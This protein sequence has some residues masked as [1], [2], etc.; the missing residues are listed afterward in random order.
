MEVQLQMQYLALAKGLTNR[1]LVPLDFDF[2]QT[3]KTN[4]KQDYYISLYRYEDRHLKLFKETNTLEGIKDVKTPKILFDFDDGLDIDAAR[5]DTLQVCA[6]LV[7]AGV[8]ED[9]IR[10]YFSGNKGFG[11]EVITDAELTRQE[12]VNVVFNLA[13]DLKTFDT[14]INDEQR[15]IRAPLSRHPVSK[16][17]KIPLSLHD[18]ASKSIDEIREAA[19]SNSFEQDPDSLY[20]ISF[21]DELNVLKNKE[22]KKVAREFNIEDIKG[23][24]ISDINFERC[25]KWLPKERYALQEGFFYGS[26][27][28]SKGE[29]NIAFMIMAATYRN[30][31]FSAEHTLG[32]LITMAD[33]QSK[34]TKESPYTEEKLQREVINVVFNPSW[35]GGI[36]SRDEELLQITRKRF[37]LSEVDVDKPNLVKIDD[38]AVRFKQF[39]KT[40]DQNRI[41]TGIESIDKNVILTTGMLVGL[42]GSPGSGKTTL[43][44]T[45]IEFLSKNDIPVIYESLDMYDN[46]LYTRMLQKYSGYDMKKIID[47]FK[48]DKP[49]E[50]LLNAYAKVIEGYSNVEFNFCSG[51]TVED[52]EK[53]VIDYKNYTGK[54]PKLLVVDYLEKVHGPFSDSTANGA[55]VASRLSDIAKN[56]D[57]CVLLLLQPQKS[58]GDPREELLSM[59]KIKGASVIEQDCRVILTMWRPAY[60]PQDSSDD[61][62]M[63][64][65]V[66]KNNMGSLTQIDLGWNG[67]QGTFFELEPEDRADLK[68][69]RKK[70]EEQKVMIRDDI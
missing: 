28:I 3:V 1:E 26:E 33:K 11:V 37:N 63:S 49:D 6:R 62:Y 35:H 67:L 44:N 69:L 61:R 53:H 14:R 60:N 42:L 24:D 21:T 34:R 18:L 36:Y 15:I 8:D 5:K 16:L 39:A 29:R 50:V 66:V 19:I 38:V 47:M 27:S 57:L 70:L 13:G 23:F 20:V 43:S 59:R 40:F 58:A 31:G 46:L 65:A 51:L 41:M 7:K 25:P 32:L 9:Y 10:I 55:Y 2:Q 12:F 54:Q 30:Q 48:N 52:I 64:I 45:F 56:H 68:R 17:Y 4:K 22:Y